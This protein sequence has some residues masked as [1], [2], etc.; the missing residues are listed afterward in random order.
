MNKT[1]MKLKTKQGL[2]TYR[3]QDLHENKPEASRGS[4]QELH[5]QGE[6]YLHYRNY[7]QLRPARAHNYKIILELKDLNF[8]LK[9]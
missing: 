6:Y 2:I 8:I 4:W 7:I 9:Y 3:P 1:S 5:A